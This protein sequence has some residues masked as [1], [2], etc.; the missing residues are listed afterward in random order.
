MIK[1]NRSKYNKWILQKNISSDELFD[2]FISGMATQDNQIDNDLLRQRLKAN[3]TYRG[4]DYH[5]AP[6]TMGVRLSQA[7]FYMF[8]YKKDGKFISSPMTDM[9]MKHT[10]ERNKTFLVNLFSMQFPSPYSNT[11][12]N[13]NVFMGRLLIKLLLEERL[14]NKLYIDECIYFLPFIETI[15]EQKY[16]ELVDSIIEWRDKTY[17][18]KK[19]LFNTVPNC[20]EVFANCA[21][22]MNYYFLRIFE[23]FGV[24]N[25]IGDPKH[26][27]G[28]LFA[29]HHGNTSTMRT[30]AYAPRQ[31]YSGYV[32][33]SPAV[34]A[35]AKKLINRYSPFDKPITQEDSL[36][37]EEWIRDLYEFEPLKY[38][39]LINSELISHPSPEP[40]RDQTFVE[41]IQEMVHHSKYGTRDGKSFERSLKPLFELFRENRSVEIISGAGDTDL[42][43]VMDNERD[44]LYKVNVDAKTSR[45]S[46][47]QI[48]SRRITTHLEIHGAKYC[49]IVSPRFC[50]GVKDDIYGS[51]IVTVE[52]ESLANYCLKECTNS[53]DSQANFTNLDNLISDHLGQ[54][55]SS[56][57][58]QM[59]EEFYAF[60]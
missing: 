25:I 5:G 47:Q 40:N 44:E 28:Q 8:G 31:S 3:N 51:H 43:C 32:Q 29:F 18:V 60:S 17:F 36:S 15:D 46:T 55:I 6:N 4:R 23:K 34:L 57:L 52:A 45:T 42:L 33:L 39:N 30:D 1:L 10:M 56:Y 19:A 22:E 49:I 59:T 20:D 50:K 41:I 54:D 24:L 21:H 7:C 9:Y 35:D 38:I 13:F 12:R 16:Q 11:P 27:E 58:D 2:A 26:N 37:K 14:G 53:S 48:N